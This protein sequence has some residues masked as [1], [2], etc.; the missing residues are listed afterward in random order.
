[1][2]NKAI[3]GVKA[4]IATKDAETKPKSPFAAA[5]ELLAVPVGFSEPTEAFELT[6]QQTR[7]IID[8]AIKV[9]LADFYIELWQRC[10][11]YLNEGLAA[12][13]AGLNYLTENSK[14]RLLATETLDTH[15]QI[16]RLIKGRDEYHVFLGNAPDE[17][18][19][20]VYLGFQSLRKGLGFYTLPEGTLSTDAANYVGF[21][22]NNALQS[23]QQAARAV[24]IPPKAVD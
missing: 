5:Y 3:E 12:T 11:D 1:M 15:D 21:S 22:S 24:F 10:N 8:Q 23:L 7:I 16:Q 4:M 9:P 17:A 19:F 18:L 6:G 13:E 14:R 2:L 20:A